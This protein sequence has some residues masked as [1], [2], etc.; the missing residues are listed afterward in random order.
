MTADRPDR[1]GFAL[2][3]VV[4][5]LALLLALAFMAA[6]AARRQVANAGVALDV[7]AAEAAAAGAVEHALRHLEGPS[8]VPVGGVRSAF[9]GVLGGRVWQV[10]THRLT[11]EYH[12]LLGYGSLAG[13]PARS[14]HARLVWWLDPVV[15]V[16]EFGAVL[17]SGGGVIPEDA[18]APVADALGPGDTHP[19][20]ESEEGLADAVGSPL[21]GSGPLAAPAEWVGEGGRG[22]SPRLGHLGREALVLLADRHVA[23]A[24]T[25]AACST[26]WEG[27]VVAAD[28]TTI[29]GSGAGVLVALGSATLAPEG[30][31]DGLVLV[32]GDLTLGA[33]ARMVGLARVRGT[34]TI[35]TDA[36]VVGSVCAAYRSLRAATSLHRPLRIPDASLLGPLP[37][38]PG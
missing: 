31:W 8:S 37:P 11:R 13:A 15:R 10:Q 38:V 35:G 12:V 27:V 33:G 2:A 22:S 26:C 16:G 5:A 17:E 7:L 32:A 9:E 25:L 3:G 4:L 20:C 29:H 30:R 28:G 1:A 34:T 23:D 24:A 6:A 18:V 14:R 21:A 19:G 36:S